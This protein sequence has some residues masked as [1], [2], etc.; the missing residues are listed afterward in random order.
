M[1][2]SSRHDYRAIAYVTVPASENWRWIGT[3]GEEVV[4]EVD[5]NYVTHINMAFGMIEA[6]QFEPD[7]PGCPLKADGVVSKEA[8]KNPEDKKYHYRAA[9]QGWNAEMNKMIDCKKYLQALVKL[10]EQS[11]E[12]K[13][14]LSVGGWECDGFCYMA[15]EPE[16]RKEF[17]DSC[18]QIMREYR[19][20]GIDIDWEHPGNG[21]WGAIASCSDCVG[22]ARLLMQEMRTYVD[23]AFPGEHKLLSVATGGLV[24]WVDQKTLDALDYVNVMCYDFEPGNGEPQASMEF[25]KEG[26][27]KNLSMTADT[28][29]NRR[30]FN[31]GVPF[32]NEGGT[33]LVPYYKEW[34]G[35]EDASPERIE[36]KMKWVKENH[37]GGG[38]YWAYSMDVYQQD[39]KAKDNNQVKILQRTLYQTLNQ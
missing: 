35:Y 18:I 16:G 5:T 38:F 33:F 28:S 21:G 29:E 30:K 2:R 1:E 13:V 39:E 11:P 26:M 27:H 31:L 34:T 15:R 32:Y 37:Y 36:E 19:L 12:L 8:Y 23:A 4:S 22:D 17:I 9:L 24:P 3:D 7:R 25:A 14:L 20:D 6:Y 10:K